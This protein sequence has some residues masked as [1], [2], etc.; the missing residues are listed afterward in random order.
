MKKAVIFVFLLFTLILSCGWANGECLMIANNSV[1]ETS[2]TEKDVKLIFL[3]KKIKWSDGTK[4]H[5]A[6][7][8]NVPVH[9]ELLRKYIHKSPSSYSSFWK[10]MIVTGG[11]IPPKLFKTEE[12]VVKY[13]AERQGAI[14][15]ISSDTKHNGVKVLSIE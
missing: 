3:G 5:K 8:I 10:L 4:I 9:E 12:E 14:G 2:L 13:V 15:Y 1:P 11:G 7:I 6:G